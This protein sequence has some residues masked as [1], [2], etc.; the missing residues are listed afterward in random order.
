MNELNRFDY[1]LDRF[2][3][4]TISPPEQDEFFDLLLS[5]HY[6]DAI[7]AR[8]TSDFRA[9]IISEAADL[10]PHIAQEI[11]RNIL[12]S[13]K[14]TLATLPRRRKLFSSG[15][16]WAAAAAMLGFV[17]LSAWLLVANNNNRQAF[18]E[19]IPDSTVNNT[20]TT[21]QPLAVILPDGSSVTLQPQATLHYSRQFTGN[22]REVY[23][24]GGAF[25]NV[26]KN[27]HQPFYVYYNKVV[28]KVLGTSFNVG[29]NP[30]TGNIEVVVQTGKVQVY[31][32][33]KMI[34]TKEIAAGVIITPNQ[35]AIYKADQRIF[36]ATLVEDP[37][38]VIAAGAPGP[39]AKGSFVFE[40]TRLADLFKQ[41]ETR[42]AIEIVVENE[43][44]YNCVFSGDISEQDLYGK[45]K[46]ICLTTNADYEINGTKILIKGKGCN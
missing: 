32:N 19:F 39:K 4:K 11:I 1:L 33:E 45:L 26:A 25:F 36:E 31:E 6:D 37:Q 24:E 15:W 5:D 38:P 8:M 46:F 41:L 40:H 35:K 28:T 23:L 9:S 2:L 29:T 42:Y 16:H 34:H 20:N 43:S 7:G 12:S 3:S 17:V 27:A 13:E 44:I 22:T 30:R 18:A 10:P 14:K 21:G